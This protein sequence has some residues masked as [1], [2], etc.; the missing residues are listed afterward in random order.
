M[1]LLIPVALVALVIFF[2]SILLRLLKAPIKWL[3]KLIIHA[4]LGYVALF[5]FNFVGAWVGI[6]IGLN[7]INAAVTGVLGVPG[8]VLLLLIKYIL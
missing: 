6:S 2:F 5:V 7:W 3:G 4:I 8:V 1:T